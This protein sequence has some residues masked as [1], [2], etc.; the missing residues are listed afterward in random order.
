METEGRRGDFFQASFLT[1][2]VFVNP[3]SC[4]QPLSSFFSFFFFRA[5]D[6]PLS[7]NSRGIRAF[8]VEDGLEGAAAYVYDT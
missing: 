3:L 2:V 4:P 5:V 8:N 1:M 6:R 7:A